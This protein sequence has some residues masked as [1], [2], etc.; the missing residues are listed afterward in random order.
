MQC[1]WLRC[2]YKCT[3]FYIHISDSLC[4][5]WRFSAQNQEA[6]PSMREW[7]GTSSH[8][9]PRCKIAEQ[10]CLWPCGPVAKI[11]KRVSGR[12]AASEKAPCWPMQEP[13]THWNP[14]HPKASSL[15]QLNK[16]RIRIRLHKLQVSK[17]E[18]HNSSQKWFFRKETLGPLTKAHIDHVYII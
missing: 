13:S 2:I 15:T 16:A 12:T 14:K 3:F 1:R 5:S 8:Q 10:R 7:R 9:T 17:A 11:A 6:S 18:L 4:I